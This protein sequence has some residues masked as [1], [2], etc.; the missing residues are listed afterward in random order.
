[1][2]F[3]DIDTDEEYDDSGIPKTVQKII[4]LKNDFIDENG[5]NPNRIFVSF[6]DYMKLLVELKEISP[7]QKQTEG[8]TSLIQ[9]EVYL[10]TEPVS[11]VE[12]STHTVYAEHHKP[13]K[14]LGD[15][16]FGDWEI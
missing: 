10:T 5:K 13:D 16:L 15:E 3:V 6:E 4:E 14:G 11:R 2:A 8:L 7:E 9:C 1:M 12:Y